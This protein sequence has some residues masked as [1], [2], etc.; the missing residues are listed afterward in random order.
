MVSGVGMPA[1]RNFEVSNQSFQ[2]CKFNGLRHQDSVP[3]NASFAP[4]HLHPKQKT[5]D[6]M[7]S[8]S[9][10]TTNTKASRDSN[11]N[12][13]L[14]DS[15][16]DEGD[17]EVLV[18]QEKQESS[19]TKLSPYHVKN[20]FNSTMGG[21]DLRVLFAMAIGCTTCDL[22]DHKDAPFSKAKTYHS[23]VKPDAATL[24]LEVTRQWK[25]YFFTCHQ[26][27]PSNWKI[28]KCTDY[29]MSRPIP[30]SEAADLDFL[31]SEL[32]EWT[33]I[34]EMINESYE[35]EE[36][37]IINCSWSSDIP[38]LHLYHTLVDDTIRSAFRKAYCSK[39]RDELDGRN[40]SLFQDFYELSSE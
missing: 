7:S 21:K 33:G 23:E 10:N 2:R 29:L 14:D 13:L 12:T 6:S 37:R 11:N 38:Y 34:Q 31:E 25:A 22:P 40:S 20:Y 27:C 28:D 8:S 3:T 26:P 19:T 5:F 17:D 1:K 30:T 36:D 16:G 9:F 18:E 15:S 39:T 24:K 32:K 4:I 35:K